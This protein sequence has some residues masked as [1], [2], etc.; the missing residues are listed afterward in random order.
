M[1]DAYDAT[2]V[3]EML[4]KLRDA[5]ASDNLS[6]ALFMSREVHDKIADMIRNKEAKG[7]VLNCDIT[8]E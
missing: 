2:T 3:C 1:K 4:Y 5:I 8:H 6:C 7:C